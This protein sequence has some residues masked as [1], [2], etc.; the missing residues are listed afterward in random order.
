MNKDEIDGLGKTRYV[1]HTKQITHFSKLLHYGNVLQNKK[2]YD[3]FEFLSEDFDFIMNSKFKQRVKCIETDCEFEYL[4]KERLL[5]NSQRKLLT[6]E[7]IKSQYE[8]QQDILN[9]DYG[10]TDNGIDDVLMILFFYGMKLLILD[11]DIFVYCDL[12]DI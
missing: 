1:L 10:N 6:N 7:F 11:K 8:L 5:F 3:L 4:E 9:R 12:L 2:T